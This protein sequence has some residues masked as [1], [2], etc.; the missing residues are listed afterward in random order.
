MGEEVFIDANIFL[1]IF[2]KDEKS[3]ACKS[4]LKSLLEKN[5]WVVTSDFIIYSCLIQVQHYLKS[6]PFLKKT[7]LFFN[8]YPLLKI[9][10]P[11]LAD[12]DHAVELMGAYSLDFD[13]SL[14]VSCMHEN[15]LTQLVSLD[16]HFDKIKEIKRIIPS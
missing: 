9:Y 15:K 6:I 1:E 14:V 13:D 7:L 3:E 5:Q 12:W 16:K 2:L 8:N 10:R 11:S 4:F